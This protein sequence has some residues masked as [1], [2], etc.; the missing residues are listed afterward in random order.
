M[1]GPSY[2]LGLH[3]AGCEKPINDKSTSG[4][5][6][7]CFNLVLNADP[8]NRRKI[9]EGVRRFAR[10]NPESMREQARRAGQAKRNNPETL[11][12]LRE[13]MR[14]IQPLSYTPEAM[15]RRDMKARGQKT[16]EFR[17][18][19]CPV[20]YRD[21]YSSLVNQKG[22]RKPEAQAMIL[23]HVAADKARSEAALSPF[24]RQE[25]A[26]R[27]GAQIVANHCAP[28]FG[29]AIDYGEDKW[30]RIAS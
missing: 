19:W 27:N 25:R 15:A 7:T 22:L 6:R 23:A 11:A 30:E 28:Q 4:K 3:C 5:C 20:E 2:R 14:L 9:A 10:E 1:S 16:R 29:Q 13:R 26:L 24:E 8:E 21:Q 18:A 12:K 17:L